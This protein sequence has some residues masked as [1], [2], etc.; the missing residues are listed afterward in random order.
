M[1]SYISGKASWLRFLVS[2]LPAAGIAAL[3]CIL[4][5]GSYMGPFYD[6]LLHQRNSPPVS[7][8]ILIIDSSSGGGKIGEDILEPGAAA[9]LLYTMAELGAEA[10]II[11]VPILGLSAGTDADKAEILYR[12]DEEF[13]LLSKNIRNLF[14]A[15]RTGSVAP[16]ESARYVGELV[17]L[18]E[19]GKDR[20]VS[21]LVRRDEESIEIMEKAAAFFGSVRR[22]GD[23]HVQLIRSGNGEGS[24]IRPETLIETDEYSR[25][26]PDRDGVLRRIMPVLTVPELSGGE[27]LEKKLEHIIYGALKTR[28]EISGI[29]DYGTGLVLALRNGPSGSNKIIPLDSQGAILFEIPHSG[30][31]F[32]RIS[33]SD[34]LAYDEADRNLRRLLSEAEILGVFGETEGENNPGILYDYALAL[35]EETASLS[36]STPG[37]SAGSGSTSSD[38]KNTWID[39]R[40]RY[41]ESL[42]DFL[43]GT[44]EMNL[45]SGYE[46]IIARESGDLNVFSVMEMRDSLIRVFIA[47]RAQYNEVM[48]LRNRL[49]EALLHSFCILGKAAA[50][51]AP[52]VS[53]DSKNIVSMILDFPGLVMQKIKS[54]FQY[55]VP[56]D[57]EASALLANS[58]LTGRVIKSG[59]DF[60]LF[61]GSVL[62]AFLIC[63]LIKSMSPASTLGIGALLIVLTGMG[64]SL[65]FIFSGIWLP[66]LVP[67]AIGGSGLLVSFIW[68]L[69]AAR[70]FSGSFRLAYGPHVSRPCLRSVIHAGKPLPSQIIT[71]RAAVVV[72]KNT[73]LKSPGE[74]SASHTRAVLAFQ[75][76]ASDLFR[77]AGAAITGIEADVVTACFGSP[78]ERVYLGGKRKISPYEANIMALAAPA[79]RAVDVISEI[80]KRPECASWHFGIDLGSCT[81]AWTAVS[82]YFALGIPVQRARI[83]SRMAGRYKSR[84]IISSAV[85]EALPDLAVK[86]LDVF[87]SENDKSGGE[88]F[89]RLTVG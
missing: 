13:S 19:K 46:E 48:E 37:G 35:R 73:G 30:E 63:L 57:T 88:P 18:S 70:R 74:P 10:L 79:M 24:G 86:K 9:S 84:I 66:P 68:A 38:R 29:E 76:K 17:E 28:F 75:E 3:F 45:V 43:Y 7:Q 40:R 58:I 65:S 54:V 50:A 77:K 64:F 89:Y 71:T 2:F 8:E 51:E 78:L 44:T 31:D 15:I 41:F 72:V 16:A 85:N 83:L 14:D 25:V 61:L 49:E 4:L 6:F 20:L 47:L 87:K 5:S 12:F 34:F 42:E 33:I 32:R 22:P 26:Q 62:T 80:A 82:G 59:D 56:T 21:S 69:A 11:Q 52:A 67:M 1:T 55:T 27:A 23:L 36:G 60:H 53:G 81:F 39:L